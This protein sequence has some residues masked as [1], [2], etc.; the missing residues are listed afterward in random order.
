MRP[1]W[2]AIL[3]PQSN[4]HFIRAVTMQTDSGVA[5]CYGGQGAQ[6]PENIVF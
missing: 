6:M 4:R 1:V 5:R 3:P 2:Q